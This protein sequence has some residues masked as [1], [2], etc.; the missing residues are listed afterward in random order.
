MWHVWHYGGDVCTCM[1]NGGCDNVTLLYRKRWMWHVW[2]CG[3][4]VHLHGKRWMWCVHLHGK[5][6]MWCVHLHGKGWMWCVHLHGKGWMWCVHLHGK[7]W[8][9]CVWQGTVKGGCDICA[10]RLFSRRHLAVSCFTSVCIWYSLMNIIIRM[11]L[12]KKLSPSFQLY[13]FNLS[14]QIWP[15]RPREYSPVVISLFHC[16]H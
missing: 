15:L 12:C 13:F 16:T 8:I 5:R 2:H 14:F 4:C 10:T 7:G 9:W 6:W 3:W 11:R 1:V